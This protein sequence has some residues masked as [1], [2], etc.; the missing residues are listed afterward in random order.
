MLWKSNFITNWVLNSITKFEWKIENKIHLR[1][2]SLIGQEWHLTLEVPT[3]EMGHAGRERE[4]TLQ[5]NIKA[6]PEHLYAKCTLRVDPYFQ[7]FIL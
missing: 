7:I 6:N 5:N 1:K 4:N 3:S 2:R